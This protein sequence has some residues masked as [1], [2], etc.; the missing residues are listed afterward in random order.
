MPSDA[1][2]LDFA[3]QSEEYKRKTWLNKLINKLNV[4]LYHFRV[5]N[6]LKIGERYPLY[7]S[8]DL[9]QVDE[10]KEPFKLKVLFL[11]RFKKEPKGLRVMGVSTRP[12]V[13]YLK[14][15]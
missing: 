9:T 8:D 15:L 4:N 14:W 6:G 10:F 13:V 3:T 12:Y 7:P 1:V 11:F 2:S 5:N